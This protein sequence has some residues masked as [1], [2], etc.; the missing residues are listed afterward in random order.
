[1]RFV[2]FVLLFTAICEVFNSLSAAGECAKSLYAHSP[3]ALSLI[4][5][6]R[7]VRIVSLRAFGEQFSEVDEK[8]PFILRLL[9][10]RVIS[11]PTLS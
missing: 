6:H 7:R 5:W 3:I 8:W 11:L 1:M 10:R 4:L 2:Q 9:S